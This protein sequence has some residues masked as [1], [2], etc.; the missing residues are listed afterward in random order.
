MGKQLRGKRGEGNGGRSDSEMALRPRIVVSRRRREMMAESEGKAVKVGALILIT[1]LSA[2]VCS[3]ASKMLCVLA[4]DIV[5]TAILPSLP[6][7]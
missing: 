4:F 1:V 3:P 2:S 6:W 5:T 7:F